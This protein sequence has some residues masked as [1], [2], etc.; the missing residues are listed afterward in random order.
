[1]NPDL[2]IADKAGPLAGQ[3]DWILRAAKGACRAR[4]ERA[5]LFGSSMV[6]EPA[7][8]ILMYVF[9]SSEEGRGV[10]VTEACHASLSPISTAQRW[11]GHL[12]DRRLIVKASN[13]QDRRAALL[14]IS[15]VGRK[16][17]REFF[18]TMV[19]YPEV[20]IPPDSISVAG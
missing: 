10:T 4:R 17:M 20:E 11:I 9:V 12:V 2:D 3:D 15:S 5:K 16:K 14:Y 19:T 8:D 18:N 13:P 7:W 1:M 6:S